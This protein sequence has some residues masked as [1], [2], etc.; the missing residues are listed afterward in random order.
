MPVGSLIAIHP[1]DQAVPQT[2]AL[3]APMG[4]TSVGRFVL[5]AELRAVFKPA[6]KASACVEIRLFIKN[7]WNDGAARANRIAA[8]AIV[9]SSSTSVNPQVVF[10]L[11]IFDFNRLSW[12]ECADPMAALSRRRVNFYTKS[13]PTDERSVSGRQQR[14][15][16]IGHRPVNSD[17]PLTEASVAVQII[18]ALLLRL[19]SDS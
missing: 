3:A 19:S 1:A 9:T 16:A 11:S 15:N 12:M 7:V 10:R 17:L 5:S 2:V 6:N 13:V 14:K 8:M 4:Q 18:N